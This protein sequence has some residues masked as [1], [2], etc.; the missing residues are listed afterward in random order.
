MATQTYTYD[1]FMAKAK[2][3]GLLNSMS[4]ADMKLAQNNPDAGMSILQYRLDYQNAATD[5]AKALAHAGA[6]NVRK[7]YG[8]YSGGDSGSS[9]YLQNDSPSDYGQ[10]RTPAYENPYGNELKD[11]LGAVT[12]RQDYQS[13]YRDQMQNLLA[14]VTDTGSFSYDAASDPNYQ[15]YAKQYRREGERAVADTLGNAAALTGGIPSSYAVTA[16]NQ[17]GDYYATQLS[18]KL[19]ELNGAAYD[20]YV[21]EKALAQNAYET[22]SAA[23]NTDYQRYIDA[24]GLDYDQLNA[25]LSLDTASY[26]KF[27]DQLAQYN[28][29]R[30]FGYNQWLD[31]LYYHRDKETAA[32]EQARAEKEFNAGQA[33]TGYENELQKALYAAEYLGNYTPLK[34]LLGL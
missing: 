19:P 16:A 20:R 24:L 21:K 25:V 23:D 4:D 11:A 30:D 6:E 13:S 3:S 32:T 18:D 34:K 8:G 5:E 9:F 33:Q 27:K 10:K 28:T 31:E 22:L 14:A 12:H 15:A 1:D 2:S 26:Q 29:D 7:Q 17:A